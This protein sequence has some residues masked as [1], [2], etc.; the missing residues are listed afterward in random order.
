MTYGRQNLKLIHKRNVCYPYYLGVDRDRDLIKDVIEFYEDNVG[1]RYGD[2]DWEEL[3]IIVGDDKLYKAL[4]KIMGHFYKPVNE[5]L[6][7][8]DPKNLRARAFQLVNKLYGG[9]VPSNIRDEALEKIKSLLGID[10]KECLDTI[11][12]IDEVDEAVLKRLEK[13]L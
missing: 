7:N 13:Y 2:I 1:K 8:L 3:K 11:L 12:W 6:R 5:N 10:S 4:I 9:F